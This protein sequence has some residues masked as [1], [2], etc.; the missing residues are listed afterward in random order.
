MSSALNTEFLPHYK[1]EDYVQWEGRWEIIYGVP[2]A[3]SPQPAFEHQEIS[4]KIAYELGAKLKK[5]ITYLPILPIDWQIT[6]DTVVQPDNLVVKG[7]PT[8]SKLTEAPVIIFEILSPSTAAKDRKL[9]YQLYQN[10]G[11]KY[12][13]IADPA[14]RC[15]EIYELAN[16]NKEYRLMMTAKGNDEFTFQLEGFSF[17]F[18]FSEIW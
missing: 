18:S 13:V 14:K 5:Q 9:K 8:G 16:D 15:A 6:E 3:M 11:V 1:Y 10:A 4:Q 7:R 2:Y 12:Y 17:E